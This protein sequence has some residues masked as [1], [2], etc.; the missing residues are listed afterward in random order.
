M[1]KGRSRRR[2]STHCRSTE[3]THTHT[4]RHTHTRACQP[5][6]LR[7]FTSSCVPQVLSG[8][9]DAPRERT[10]APEATSL[11]NECRSE[12]TAKV[13]AT[14][15]AAAATS[16]WGVLFDIA[17]QK[18]VQLVATYHTGRDSPVRCDVSP[19]CCHPPTTLPCRSC[20][21]PSHPRTQRHVTQTHHVATAATASI[22]VVAECTFA[23]AAAASVGSA[24][25]GAALVLLGGRAPESCGCALPRAP[26]CM[27]SSSSASTTF[28]ASSPLGRWGTPVCRAGELRSRPSRPIPIPW[29]AQGP[30]C[31]PFPPLGHPQPL[32]MSAQWTVLAR[33]RFAKTAPG[34][35]WP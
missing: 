16:H 11:A 25:L 19:L 15:A 21:P 34:V 13:V 24:T 30:R 12:D 23:L 1:G 17:A 28:A 22:L 31:A 20:Q 35:Y 27:W 2:D 9:C 4:K 8:D 3:N 6:V 10:G 33:G 18:N 5:T 7:K 32:R 14:G 29:S 26:A